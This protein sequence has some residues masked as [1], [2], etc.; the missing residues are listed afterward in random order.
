MAKKHKL[1]TTADVDL[2]LESIDESSKTAKFDAF[3]EA[4]N[5]KL[6]NLQL[7]CMHLDSSQGVFEQEGLVEAHGVTSVLSHL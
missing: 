3:A 1:L 5:V 6:L 2:P 7:L 4:L